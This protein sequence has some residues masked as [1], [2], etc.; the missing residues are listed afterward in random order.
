MSEPVRWG[1]IGAGWIARR[2]LAPAVHAAD[3]AVLHAAAA[4]EPARAAALGPRVT[5]RAYEHLLGDDEVEAVYISL[6]NSAHLPW[7]LAALGSGKHVLCEKPLGLTADQVRAM[8]DAAVGAGRLLVEATWSQW[9]PR[10]R[11]ARALLASDVIG[12]V[13]SV[14]TG[15]RFPGV[16]E[17]NYRLDPGHGGGALYD[18]GPYAV[19]AALWATPPDVGVAVERVD[20]RLSAAGIDL[21]TDA[22]LRLGT[23]TAHVRVSI[24]D[25]YGEWARI[26]GEH[27]SLEL[28]AP[29]YTSWL[30]PS[31]LT[32]RRPEETLVQQ[33]GPVDAY[34]LMVEHVSRA[35]RGDASAFV[36]PVEES[37][38][39]AD[40]LD[41]IRRAHP[42]RRS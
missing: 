22:V 38:R 26:E 14:Q 37:V 39:V 23:A 28:S 31:T 35:V 17:G 9:H 19:G 7:T 24:D 16:P 34:Q 18:V 2:A 10:T 42:E 30:A 11:R 29:A 36:V 3:G 1:F 21:A 41:D 33:F 8:A 27:G 40:A 13:H 15:F 25:D 32:V 6:H 4:R 20:G 5:Y 12:Q